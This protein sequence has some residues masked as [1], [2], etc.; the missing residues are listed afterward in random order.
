MKKPFHKINIT[1]DDYPE[2][3]KFHFENCEKIMTI[4]DYFRID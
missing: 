1:I 3:R 2:M 4:A